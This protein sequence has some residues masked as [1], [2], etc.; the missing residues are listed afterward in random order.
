VFLALAS[1]YHEFFGAELTV[2]YPTGSGIWVTLDAVASDLW[3]RLV[4]IFLLGSDESRPCFG[5]VGRFRPTPAGATTRYFPSTFTA[6]TA[7]A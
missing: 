3:E 1:S 2:E 6:I 5:G 4:S 7:R